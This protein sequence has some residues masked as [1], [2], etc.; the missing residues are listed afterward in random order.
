MV[1]SDR[2]AHYRWPGWVAICEARGLAK[3]MSGKGR[4]QDNAACEGFFGRL[5]NE[6][7]HYRDWDGVSREEF[8]A[9]PGPTSST[10]ATAGSRSRWAG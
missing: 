2:G 3:S 7:F 8:A 6:F 5:K 10:T 1:H 9:R 4:S